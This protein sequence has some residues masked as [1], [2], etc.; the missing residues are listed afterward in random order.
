MTM[1]SPKNPI[2]QRFPWLSNTLP[3][4]MEILHISWQAQ[5]A[6]FTG[7]LLGDLLLSVIPVGRAWLTK[8]LFDLLAQS[9]QEGGAASIG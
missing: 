4:V 5:P 3:A 2:Y 6:C 8:L 7:L 1:P 9:F